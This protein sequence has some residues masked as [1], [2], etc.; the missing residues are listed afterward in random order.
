MR[1]HIKTLQEK[2]RDLK[3][4]EQITLTLLIITLIALIVVSTRKSEA[5]F[6]IPDEDIRKEVVV[7]S[8]ADLSIDTGPLTIIGTVQSESQVD[9]RTESSGS[10]TY[11]AASLGDTVSRGQV[12]AEIE[13]SSERA[14]VAQAEALLNAAQAQLDSLESSFTESGDTVAVENARRALLSSDLVAEPNN[15]TQTLTP[16]VISGVYLGD[17]EGT[18]TFRIDRGNRADDFEFYLGGIETVRTT[19]IIN[20]ELKSTP[21]GTYGLKVSF[22]EDTKEYFE[23][24]WIVRVPNTEGASYTAN[25]NAYN[26]ALDAQSKTLDQIRVQEAQVRSARSSLDA[27]QAQ[28]EKTIIRSPI[29]GTV[30]RFD[31][32]TGDFVSVFDDV[33][34]VANDNRMEIKTYITENDKPSLEV[35]LPAIIAGEYT[36]QITS[37]SPAVD[38]ATKKIEVSI[39]VDDEEDLLNG[40]SVS[41][42]ITRNNG[43]SREVEQVFI[44]LSALKVTA[45][46]VVVFSIDGNNVITQHL[47]KEGPLVGE[48]VL[49]REGLTPDMEIITDVRGIAVGDTVDT[50]K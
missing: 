40:Q 35:G 19:E 47:V 45:E 6:V 39:S 27:A 32:D 16:P 21:L 22:V 38:P 28:L 4:W 50:I 24:K 15:E 44:P 42:S 31:I 7:R 34:T 5:P 30:N 17:E 11:V 1:G 43:E 29:T 48:K 37:I 33:A 20:N 9:I 3:R 2:Y 46:G 23:T 8:V 12:L 26:A 36:G 18:Y 49:I 10:I 25:L 13:N 14:A 41:V